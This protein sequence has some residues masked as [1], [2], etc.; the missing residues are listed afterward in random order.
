VVGLGVKNLLSLEWGIKTL[1]V[2][3]CMGALPLHARQI[4]SIGKDLHYIYASGILAMGG[5]DLC[6]LLTDG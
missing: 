1:P 4:A 5:T 2:G 6:D 3:N